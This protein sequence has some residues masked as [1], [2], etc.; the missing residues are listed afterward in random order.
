MVRLLHAN[1]VYLS[2]SD[3]EEYENRL[4]SIKS[5]PKLEGTLLF[6]I[7]WVLESR[8]ITQWVEE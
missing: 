3:L 6:R 2:V 8:S 5:L 1:G 4:E 7:S